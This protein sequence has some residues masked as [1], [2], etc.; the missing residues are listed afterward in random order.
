MDDDRLAQE[1][2]RRWRAEMEAGKFED[3]EGQRREDEHE[4]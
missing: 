3:S 4:Q 1:I 2:L